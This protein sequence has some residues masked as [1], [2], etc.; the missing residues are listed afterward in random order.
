VQTQVLDLQ[1]IPINPVTTVR[2]QV[3]QIQLV[4]ITA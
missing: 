1:D 2:L 4:A 3:E